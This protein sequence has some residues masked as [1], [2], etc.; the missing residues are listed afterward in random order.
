MLTLHLSN[1]HNIL[2]RYDC[3]GRIERETIGEVAIGGFYFIFV[4][5]MDK[6]SYYVEGY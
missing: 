4:F 6:L 1:F 3:I 2:E 5:F